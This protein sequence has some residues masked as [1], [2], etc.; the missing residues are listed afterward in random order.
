MTADFLGQ[1]THF[2]DGVT[3]RFLTIDVLALFN[4]MHGRS[5]MSVIRQSHIY[6]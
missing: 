3:E 5:E 4:G 2:V 1:Q 6:T